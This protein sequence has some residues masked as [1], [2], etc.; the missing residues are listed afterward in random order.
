[1]QV[2]SGNFDFIQDAVRMRYLKIVA[3]FTGG[4]AFGLVVTSHILGYVLKRWHQI[5][6]AIIIGFIT[7]SLG[8]VW[9]WK[10]EIYKTENGQLLHDFNGDKVIE[11]YQRF[12]PDVTLQET[13]VAVIFILLGVG[14]LLVLDQYS[15]RTKTS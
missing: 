1:M 4:S 14:M 12:M 3:V 11:N 10:R 5:V 6:T 8:I 7:G 15:K 2:F 9:P 13:W